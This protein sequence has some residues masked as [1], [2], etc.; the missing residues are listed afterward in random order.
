[1]VPVQH[2]RRKPAE[3]AK[4]ALSP[5]IQPSVG[6]S[7]EKIITQT[8]THHFVVRR[9]G[10]SIRSKQLTTNLGNPCYSGSLEK[11]WV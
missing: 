9:I 2:S 7:G 4:T 1:V 10:K 5:Y 11:S 3:K 6:I 8:H